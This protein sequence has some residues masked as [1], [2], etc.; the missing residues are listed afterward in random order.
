MNREPDM[1]V[2]PSSACCPRLTIG[3]TLLSFPTLSRYAEPP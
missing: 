2:H 3:L 1:K